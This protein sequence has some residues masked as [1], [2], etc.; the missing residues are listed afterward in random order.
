MFESIKLWIVQV[1]QKQ[2]LHSILKKHCFSFCLKIGKEEVY[3]KIESGRIDLVEKQLSRTV[4]KLIEGSEEVFLSI[5]LGKRK[6]REAIRNQDMTTT[7]S[8]R[9]LLLF[10]T[11]FYLS[12]GALDV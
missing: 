1:N 10:E 9:E 7:F 3:L 4:E 12:L 11:L 6:L 8:F 2:V 5:L